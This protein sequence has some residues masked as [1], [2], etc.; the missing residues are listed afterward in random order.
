MDGLSNSNMP[1][2][3]IVVTFDDGKTKLGGISRR[4]PQKRRVGPMGDPVYLK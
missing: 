3:Y 2:I 4:P 1:G